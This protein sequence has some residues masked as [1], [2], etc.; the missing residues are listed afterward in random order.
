MRVG[1]RGEREVAKVFLR[2]ARLL[3]RAEHEVREDALFGLAFQ[4]RRQPL[5]MMRGHAQVAGLD[6]LVGGRVTLL[7]PGGV[8]LRNLKAT[9][10]R[11]SDAE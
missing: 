1:G 10:R 11:P 3:E 6:A 7:A 8:A 2:V 5:V 4:A 9:E